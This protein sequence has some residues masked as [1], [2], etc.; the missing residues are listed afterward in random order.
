MLPR[1]LE[2]GDELALTWGDLI[3]GAPTV[4]ALAR[5]CSNSFAQPEPVDIELSDEARAILFAARERGV[6]EIRG[7]HNAF[8]SV[9]RF[10]SVS[11]EV[12]PDFYLSFKNRGEPERTV[13]FMESFRQLCLAGLVMHQTQAEF[14]LTSR[15]FALAKSIERGQVADAL[16]FGVEAGREG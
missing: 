2:R 5:I 3:A 14:S 6:I 10:L 4:I 8:D 12:E 1:N 7:S 15:G 13:A 9:Q 16:A 11:V